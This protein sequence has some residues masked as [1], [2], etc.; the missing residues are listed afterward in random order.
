[1]R[2]TT[3]ALAIREM[4]YLQIA[5]WKPNKQSVGC[6][7]TPKGKTGPALTAGFSKF[8][9]MFKIPFKIYFKLGCFI[10]FQGEI[11]FHLDRGLNFVLFCV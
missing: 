11:I 5:K 9:G 10:Y 4:I 8:Q 1:M 3:F 6:C 2:G 7:T